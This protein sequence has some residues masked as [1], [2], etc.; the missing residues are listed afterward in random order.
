[1]SI[2][3][4]IIKR[5]FGLT[6]TFLWL[7]YETPRQVPSYDG[8]GGKKGRNC[9]RRFLFWVVGRRVIIK[10]IF[11]IFFFAKLPERA[12]NKTNTT[13]KTREKSFFAI[14]SPKTAKT[15]KRQKSKKEKKKRLKKTPGSSYYTFSCARFGRPLFHPSNHH[16]NSFIGIQATLTSG[17][18][19]SRAW[20]V[21]D[22]RQR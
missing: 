7:T 19:V 12:F 8:W 10:L 6:R 20:S 3:S 9:M 18:N 11:I 15:R 5:L 13:F 17:Y 4:S 2:L 14:F 21:H 22:H 1:M 16:P